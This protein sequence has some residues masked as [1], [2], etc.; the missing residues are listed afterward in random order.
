ML[1][2]LLVVLVVLEVVQILVVYYMHMAVVVDLVEQ[3]LHWP[4]VVAAE[5][6]LQLL[7]L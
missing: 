5:V 7:V 2:V 1:P 4:Q 6:E 3:S